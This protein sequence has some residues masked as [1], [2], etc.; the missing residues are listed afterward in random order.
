M[1]TENT[2]FRFKFTPDFTS[3]L[4]SFAK[5]HQYDDRVTY[6]EAWI[7]WTQN[8]ELFVDD[9]CSRMKGLGYDG[10]VLDKMYKSGRYYF[11]K[12]TKQE[13]KQ[14]RKY[15]SIDRDVIEAM[16]NHILQNYD[17]PLFK[18]STSHEQFCHE[19]SELIDEEYTR[20]IAETLTKND[21]NNKIKKTYKNRYFLFSQHNQNT[22]TNRD[23]NCS[24]LSDITED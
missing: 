11:R 3:Q 13:P 14:R 8:N 1:T 7:R 4:L 9:E 5:L 20:L 12:K 10:D 6:K 19:Y 23:D 17:T 15:I 16:D 18:P 22:N 21:V 2:I 24:I